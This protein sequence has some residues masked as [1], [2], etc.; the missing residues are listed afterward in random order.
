VAILLLS[1][2]GIAC[3]RGE[4]ENLSTKADDDPALFEKAQKETQ[5]WQKSLEE[6]EKK[7]RAKAASQRK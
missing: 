5:E 3:G 4:S 1:L 7:A 2:T 6:A